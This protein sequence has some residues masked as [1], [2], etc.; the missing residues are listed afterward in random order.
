MESNDLDHWLI[1][2]SVCPR[3]H[4]LAP[5]VI[6]W[7]HSSEN[8]ELRGT[9]QCVSKKESCRTAILWTCSG[10]LLLT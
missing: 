5:M 7:I 3:P 1:R 6:S 8:A 10:R 2:A 9:V 4:A